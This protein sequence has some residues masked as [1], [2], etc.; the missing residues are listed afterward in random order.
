MST[1]RPSGSTISRTTCCESEIRTKDVIFFAAA[2]FG[3]ART[4]A[5]AGINL[6]GFSYH[7]DQDK[8]REMGIDNQ[9]NPGLG[10]RWRGP[11]EAWDWMADVGFYRD[12]GRNTAR[13]A[14]GG[15]LW[16]ATEAVR[17]GGALVLLK[18]KT[19]NGGDAFVAPVPVAAYDFGRATFNMVYFPKWRDVNRTNQV[20]F[21]LTWW[22]GS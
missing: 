13:L 4:H 1:S 21:W 11:R 19:Y 10:L 20:G 9:V 18:S 6:Y 17:L 5:D 3:C 12:S 2:A 15:A 16:H 22:L 14:G 7:F 8:A